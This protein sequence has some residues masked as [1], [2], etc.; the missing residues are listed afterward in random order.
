MMPAFYNNKF[1]SSADSGSG[2]QVVVDD[3]VLVA[4]NN[5]IIP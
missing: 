2:Y 1:L 3:I 4:D 5:F